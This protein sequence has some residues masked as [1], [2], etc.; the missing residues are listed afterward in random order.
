M[1][2][3]L[4]E[5]TNRLTAILEKAGSNISLGNI[6]PGS[7]SFVAASL[8]ARTQKSSKKSVLAVVAS[9]LEAES[10]AAES[11]LFL[12]SGNTAYFPDYENIP[13]EYAGHSGDIA[14]QRMRVIHRILK[15]EQLL[16]FAPPGAL[17]RKMQPVNRL[18]ASMIRLSTGQNFSIDRLSQILSQNG[19]ERADRTEAPGEFSVKGSIVDIFPVNEDLPVR[20]DYFDET[21]DSIRL[22]NPD[23]QIG[24]EKAENCLLLPSGE[25]SLNH[26]ESERLLEFL[27]RKEFGGLAAPA[28]KE[29]LRRRLD[30]KSEVTISS[31]HHPGMEE[32]FPAACETAGLFDY[33]QEIPLSVFYPWT[34]IKNT[35]ARFFREFQHMYEK[36]SPGRICLAPDMLLNSEDSLFE[37]DNK[38]VC[39]Y[40]PVTTPLNADGPAAMDRHDLNL[41]HPEAFLGKM[42]DVRDTIRSQAEKGDLVCITSPYSAQMQRLTGVFR[43][44]RN[45]LLH[46]HSESVERP[47]VSGKPGIHIIQSGHRHGFIIPD[48]NFFLWSDSDIFGRSYARRSRFKKAGSTPL[49]SFIDLKEK[50]YVVHINHGV[51][52]FLQ[53]ERIK[54]AGRERD[55]LVLEFA[56]SDKLYVP[57]DQIS[58][59]QKYIAPVE[60]PRL[61]S[62]GK[63]SFKKIKERVEKR[64]E[65]LAQDLIQIYAA[66][67][68]CKGFAFPPDTNWQEEF[69]ADFEYE[70]TPDQITAI[71][72][73]KKDME[74]GR[75]MDRL[76]CG[77]VGY[78]KTEVAI[79]AAFKAVMAGRQVALIAP[80]TILA[81]Q[82][83]KNFTERFKNY[84]VSVD[85]ISR[86]R[87]RKEIQDLR[88]RI[89][90]GSVDVIIGTHSLLSKKLR[91]KNLGLLIIDEEQRFGVVHKEAIKNLKKLVDVLTLSA[92]PIP[93]TL[94]MSLVGIRDLSIIQTPPKDRLP[95]QTFVLEDSDTVIQEA[96]IR[97]ISRKGQVFY[98]HNRIESIETEAQRI[99]KLLPEISL[100]VLHG[101]MD[102]EAIEET[103]LDFVNEKYNVLVTTSI[104]ESG[105]DMPNVNTLIVDRADTFGLSQLYQ[106][107]GRVGRSNRQAYAYLLHPHGRILS[108]Q[109][110]KRLNTI[111]EYQDLGS[112]FKVAMRD[113]EIRGAGN[114]LGREQSGD[115]MDVGFELYVRLLEDAVRRLKGKKVEVEVRTS[116]NLNTDFYLPES[117]IQDTRQRIEFYKRYEAARTDDEVQSVLLEMEER[118]GS[119]P[120]IAVIFVLVEKIR[121]LSSL[122]GFESVYEEDTGKVLF[123]SG[124]DF[125]VPPEQLI[126]VLKKYENI[127]IKPGNKDTLFFEFRGPFRVRLEKMIEI[128]SELAAP[129]KRELLEN[130]EEGGTLIYFKREEQE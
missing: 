125:R 58:M 128:L 20:I 33:F 120:E 62:L 113:L 118:F 34:E 2:A 39:E 4:E 49:D 89:A 93:R 116:I 60:I 67:M 35:T 79:R 47:A 64:V 87:S 46:P 91:M 97:E 56:D 31:F 17:L 66:R 69:E 81:L 42:S 45:L 59:V 10:C 24:K 7:F 106:I 15:G 103:L 36:E 96:I 68:K 111:L 130:Q 50:D 51:G 73:V 1:K 86:F 110:Q 108:E 94:H 105:I 55:F 112:G 117:Y 99:S 21:I 75:P 12:S 18:K 11:L 95:V 124:E 48:L 44:D 84:P 61:D 30:E 27:S 121:T 52:R 76:V 82:H 129:L 26:A 53:M 57:L 122:A 16:I 126:H 37:R 38:I 83:F 70:E 78:G 104:I 92:T 9:N 19:Y 23:T 88:Q 8:F 72:A 54:A 101:R 40:F 65:E 114:I 29:D 74:T 85:W 98:L 13:Y 77:D 127:R 102:D 115:I 3:L 5:Y 43:G 107:R 25:I 14:M 6:P 90:A 71:D 41:K 63:A 22:Y 119:P 109:A 123:K 80:T 32:L 100:T 28:W